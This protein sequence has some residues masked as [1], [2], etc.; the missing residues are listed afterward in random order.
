MKSYWSCCKNDYNVFIFLYSLGRIALYSQQ[1]IQYAIALLC[2]SR[3]ISGTI[4]NVSG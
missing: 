3:D 4:K 2:V 1:D